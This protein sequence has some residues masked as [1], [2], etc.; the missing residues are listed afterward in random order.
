M[1]MY[2][3]DSCYDCPNKKECKENQ[4]ENKNDKQRMSKIIFNGTFIYN[5]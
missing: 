5:N 3:N 2:G 1:C 4:E